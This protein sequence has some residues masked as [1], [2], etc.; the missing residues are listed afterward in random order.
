MI[1]TLRLTAE[2]ALGLLERRRSRRPSC[3]PPIWP[4]PGS[5]TTSSTP[6]LR[7]V[8][9]DGGSG[10]PDRAQGRDLDEGRRDDGRLEDPRRL[11]AGL[12]LDGRGTLQGSGDA[13]DRQDEHGRVRDGLVDREL[14]LRAV[15]QPVGPEPRARWL[16]WRHGRGRLRWAR[17]LGARLR[18]RRLDQAAVRALRQR[19]PP[20]DL[21]HGLALRDRR[22]R[23]EPRSDRPGRED[24]ARRGASLR[25][26]LR[27]R[28]ERLDD[29]RAPRGGRA[30]DRGIARRGCASESRS[31]SGTCPVSSPASARRSRRRSRPRG[32]SAPRSA[33]ATCRSPST[34][35]W[36]AT[37]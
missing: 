37:T 4:R 10:V 5:A 8:E 36:R 26:H 30:A 16:G 25:D 3:T 7:L 28:R 21:R 22:V 32:R 34:T 13:G 2:D 27:P 12:R 24:G 20:P 19:R 1:D 14:G 17:A 23:V 9:F 11:R 15:A 33:S 18:H 6:Y 29:R 35:G 31:R